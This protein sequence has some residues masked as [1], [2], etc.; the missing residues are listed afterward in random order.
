MYLNKNRS[1]EEIVANI[2][3]VVM[4]EPRKTHIMYGANLSYALLCK[5]LNQLV[6]CGMVKYRANDRVY[7]LTCNGE[8]YLIKYGEYKQQRNRLEIER[9]LLDEKMA[10][11]NEIL[12]VSTRPSDI[13]KLVIHSIKNTKVIHNV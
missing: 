1:K 12:E 2:L 3:T 5:Y 11:L 13:K 6:D 8:D 10:N 4:R 9:A 7:E